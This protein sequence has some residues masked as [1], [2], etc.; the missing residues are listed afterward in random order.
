MQNNLHKTFFSIFATLILLMVMVPHNT[1]AAHGRLRKG[2]I[3][4]V[5]SID[6]GR[7]SLIVADASST[8]YAIDYS[9]AT[10]YSGQSHLTLTPSGVHTGD[11]VTITGNFFEGA[12][13]FSATKISDITFV[14]H[15]VFSGT[16]ALVLF[17]DSGSSTFTLLGADG[18]IYSVDASSATITQGIGAHT[19]DA[20]FSDIQRGDN[21]TV[22]GTVITGGKYLTI[23]ADFINDRTPGSSSGGGGGR[24]TCGAIGCLRT[25]G[26]I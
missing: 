4:K 17:S 25:G 20:L 26:G 12:R 23:T 3:G 22:I 13:R 9:G 14:Q 16:V 19:T 21:V 10:F 7:Q 18:N 11:I 5:I 24:G 1:F 15:T 6:H 2:V 8:H